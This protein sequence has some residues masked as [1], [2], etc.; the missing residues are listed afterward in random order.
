MTE[1]ETRITRDF[2]LGDYATLQDAT[3]QI[4]FF[5]GRKPDLGLKL[6]NRYLRDGLLTLALL[7]PDSSTLTIF[8]KGECKRRKV[9]APLVPAEGVRVDPDK[10]VVTL[11]DVGRLYTSARGIAWAG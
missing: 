2:H 1:A 8:S 5:V 9:W 10:G 11:P 3:L 7:S 4:I 6:T